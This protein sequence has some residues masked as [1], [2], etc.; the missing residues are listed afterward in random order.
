MKKVYPGKRE[1]RDLLAKSYASQG[2]FDKGIIELE[3]WLRIDPSD[4][5]AKELLQNIKNIKN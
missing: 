2:Q 4:K 3:E 5:E 1:I